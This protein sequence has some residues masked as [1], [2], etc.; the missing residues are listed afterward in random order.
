MLA[1]LLGEGLVCPSDRHYMRQDFKP[2]LHHIN[3]LAAARV[4]LGDADEALT[5]LETRE[6][7]EAS[8]A[9]DVAEVDAV[10][11]AAVPAAK[12]GRPAKRV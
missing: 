3:S 10:E 11:V 12:R 7:L 8:D 2:F 5:G 6:T 9:A 4:D 1:V